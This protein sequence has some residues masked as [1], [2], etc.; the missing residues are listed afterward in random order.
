L[1]G[2]KTIQELKTILQ[3]A[4]SQNPLGYPSAWDYAPEILSS[5]QIEEIGTLP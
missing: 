4:Q 1:F 3:Q 2:V 5:I